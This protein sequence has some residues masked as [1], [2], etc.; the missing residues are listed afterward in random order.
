MTNQEKRASEEAKQSA[1]DE[2][3]RNDTLAREQA[4]E[5]ESVARKTKELEKRAAE[6]TKQLARDQVRRGNTL[7]KEKAIAEEQK[8]RRD[9][10]YKSARDDSK[11]S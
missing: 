10:S 4:I 8:A 1:R 2:A 11:D 6:E 3:R 5:K 7:A 9:G